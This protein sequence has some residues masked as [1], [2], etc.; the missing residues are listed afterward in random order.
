MMREKRVM[1]V[2]EMRPA[3]Q[4]RIPHLKPFW[5]THGPRVEFQPEEILPGYSPMNL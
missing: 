2:M 4:K 1:V 5:Q 3:H